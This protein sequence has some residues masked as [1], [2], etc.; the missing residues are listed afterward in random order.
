MIKDRTS[1][2]H[3]LLKKQ[4]ILRL[5][6][7]ELDLA[8]IDA[9]IRAI[10]PAEPT[11]DNGRGG[12]DQP[13]NVRGDRGQMKDHKLG[14]IERRRGPFCADLQELYRLW[15]SGDFTS[16]V[17]DAVL[18][19]VSDRPIR[20]LEP[21][22]LIVSLD[23]LRVKIWLSIMKTLLHMPSAARYLP[24]GQSAVL[25]GGNLLNVDCYQWLP[26]RGLNLQ[27][28]TEPAQDEKPLASLLRW[29]LCS[30]GDRSN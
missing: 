19:E 27:D 6:Q 24:T 30:W 14:L 17:T 16:R 3:R 11:L 22:Y 2:I 8:Q 29:L 10:I 9:T 13:E 20:A 12:V 15:L 7:V 21:M 18:A 23:A 28:P 26:W 25:K 1:A 4:S 5:R